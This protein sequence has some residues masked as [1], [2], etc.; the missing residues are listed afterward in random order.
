M[1]PSGEVK[2]LRARGAVTVDIRWE[3][4]KATA[5]TLRPEFAGNYRLR[6][7]AG[8]R[9]KAVATLSLH[10]ES[11]GSVQVALEANR[12]YGIRFA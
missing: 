11:D 9:I 3:N 6:A 10:H 2:G 4:G 12:V 5:A 1:W 7:P 8:Q